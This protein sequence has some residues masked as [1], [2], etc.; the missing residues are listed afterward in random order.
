MINSNSHIIINAYKNASIASRYHAG[1]YSI[2]N[3]AELNNS[4]PTSEAAYS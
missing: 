1:I 2:Q 3:E 4:N